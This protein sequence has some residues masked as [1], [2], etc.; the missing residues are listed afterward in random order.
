MTGTVSRGFAGLFCVFAAMSLL[1]GQPA[2]AEDAQAKEAAANSSQD[3]RMMLSLPGPDHERLNALIGEWNTAIK[4]WRRPDDEAVELAGSVTCRWTLDG[5]FVEEH[6]EDNTS[7]GGGFQSLG[8]LG[9]NRK[10]ELYERF[11]MT[12][13]ST[14][15]FSE[16]GR[17]DPDSNLIRTRGTEI[18][19]DSGV[20]IL[21]ASEL[22]IESPSRH[23][24]TAYAT[25]ADG[26][27]WKQLEIV[28]TK[29]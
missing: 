10:T 25:G 18:D 16:R 1:A 22:N 23:I 26:V 27:R 11:W 21:T 14:G 4:Y 28:Y 20:V 24:L 9:Y 7:Q 15:M 8:Y 13:T 2:Q 6:A 3:R 12:N 17:Y 29:K 5:R 19:P